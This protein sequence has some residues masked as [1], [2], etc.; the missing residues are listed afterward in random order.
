M[1]GLGNDFIIFDLRTTKY[2]FSKTEIIKLADR[3][4]G[5]GC[6]QFIV[7]KPCKE[8]DI[9]MQIYN[10][11]ASRAEACGNAT[12]CVTKLIAEPKLTIKVNERLLSA[13]IL[14]DGSVKVNMGQPSYDWQKIPLASEIYPI[15]MRFEGVANDFE[16]G[17]AVSVGNPHLVFFVNNPSELDLAAHGSYFENH[18]YFPNRTNVNFAQIVNDSEINL[19]TWE[20]GTGET[21]ACGSGA[22]ATAAIAHKIGHTKNRAKINLKH[23]S[24]IIEVLTDGIYMTG[25]STLVF[26][27]EISL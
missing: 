7:V 9:E 21:L 6:D 2:D 27:G 16:H 13:E 17:H 3:H 1:H 5:I 23:G 10:P 15:N 8:A 19:T 14:K 4:L 12:R 24:L 25:D 26:T 11:D 22:C 18:A 20:R